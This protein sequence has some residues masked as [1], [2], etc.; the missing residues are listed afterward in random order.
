[1]KAVEYLEPDTPLE[2][3]FF[4][5]VGSWVVE[6]EN[7]RYVGDGIGKILLP[8]TA[9]GVNFVAAALHRPLKVQ[10]FLDDQP[11]TQENAGK[12]IQI[13]ST[14]SSFVVIEE[15]RLYSLVNDRRGY[16]QHTLTLVVDEK[17]LEAYTFTFG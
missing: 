3:N 7:I 8:Y 9:K 14:G 16:G 2:P 12:D 17:G 10:V 6:N 13:D 1:M 4:Y 15:G 5:L 11:L